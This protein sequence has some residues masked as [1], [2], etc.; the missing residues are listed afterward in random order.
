MRYEL[1]LEVWS[2]LRHLKH[3]K[4]HHTFKAM[5]WLFF[6]TIHSCSRY[7]GVYIIS[8]SHDFQLSTEREQTLPFRISL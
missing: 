2:W 1:I 6:W 3:R 5:K 4:S 7:V 8:K